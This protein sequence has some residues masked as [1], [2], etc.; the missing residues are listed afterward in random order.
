M[1]TG[2]QCAHMHTGMYAL[3][4]QEGSTIGESHRT[5]EESMKSG[6]GNELD[7]GAACACNRDLSQ[8]SD[9]DGACEGKHPAEKATCKQ[10]QRQPCGRPGGCGERYCASKRRQACCVWTQRQEAIE[11]HTTWAAVSTAANTELQSQEHHSI[12]GGRA[13]YAADEQ[14]ET[15]DLLKRGTRCR[16]SGR[17]TCLCQSLVATKVLDQKT[18]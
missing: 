2:L 8:D 18:R 4:A 16:Q 15:A 11:G 1:R 5:R 9:S 10:A 6:R 3:P 14:G 13:R 12:R 17:G 7:P